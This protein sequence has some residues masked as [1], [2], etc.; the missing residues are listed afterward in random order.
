MCLDVWKNWRHAEHHDYKKMCLDVWKNWRHAEYH[1]YKKMCLDVWKNWRHAEYH[2]YKKMCLDVW[3][4]WR[5]AEYHD[6]K[7]CAWMCERIGD[8]QSITTTK[9]VLGCVKEFE[10]RRV[11]QT[12]KNVLGCVKELETT[13]SITTTKK[14]AWMCERIGDTQSITTTKNVLGCVKKFETR[15][16]SRPQ[17]MEG[18]QSSSG[19]L[20]H[21]HPC[22]FSPCSQR[23]SVAHMRRAWHTSRFV[24]NKIICWMPLNA[25][26]PSFKR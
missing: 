26:G 1:D 22:S 23:S 11:S 4:N 8:T 7:K 20:N 5:H 17:R 19:V 9:N 2:D 18:N 24:Y 10:T 13:Q 15:R 3:K 12:T 21:G 14:C 6:Y 16:V 25:M